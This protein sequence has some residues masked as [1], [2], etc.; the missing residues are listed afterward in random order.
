MI[1]ISKKGIIWLNKKLAIEFF[2]TLWRPG[3]LFV[4]IPS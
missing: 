2:H 3:G 4:A 1:L